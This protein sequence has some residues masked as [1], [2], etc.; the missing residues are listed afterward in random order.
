M[1]A[2]VLLSRLACPLIPVVVIDRLDDAVPLAEAL[3]QGGVSA[4]SVLAR[5]RPKVRTQQ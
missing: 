1:D 5:M 3:M 4:S 2:S